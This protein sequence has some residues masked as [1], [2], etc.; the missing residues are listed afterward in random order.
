MVTATAIRTWTTAATND[1]L[2]SHVDETTKYPNPAL[3]SRSLG[4][5]V[6]EFAGLCKMGVDCRVGQ[7][8]L[9]VGQSA[10]VRRSDAAADIA[11]DLFR[12]LILLLQ[13]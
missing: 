2:A 5:A 10:G 1:S 13:P 8:R 9:L 12:P 11:E 7:E 6:P 3:A 4:R